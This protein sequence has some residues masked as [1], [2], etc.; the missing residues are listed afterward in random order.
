MPQAEYRSGVPED[1]FVDPVRLGIP[2]IRK[3]NTGRTLPDEGDA[4]A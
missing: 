1:W 4:L 2:G 3:D